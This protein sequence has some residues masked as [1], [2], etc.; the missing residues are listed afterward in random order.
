MSKIDYSW[1]F[2]KKVF[3]KEQRLDILRLFREQSEPNFH[4][5]LDILIKDGYFDKLRVAE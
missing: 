1:D 5:F 2:S 3:T 4:K